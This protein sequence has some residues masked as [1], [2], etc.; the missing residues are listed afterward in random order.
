MDGA[1]CLNRG[2]R[3]HAIAILLV[4]IAVTS[5]CSSSPTGGPA[6]STAA[7]SVIAGSEYVVTT[8]ADSSA[9]TYTGRVA[10]VDAESIVMLDPVIEG[11]VVESAPLLRQAPY[12]GRLF[13]NTGVARETRSGEVRIPLTE[14]DS[15]EPL[16]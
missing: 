15:V 1:T 5:G 10:R 8:R 4:S 11:R 3:I 2:V 9:A 7:H 12:V 13:K 14:V 16:E 6:V